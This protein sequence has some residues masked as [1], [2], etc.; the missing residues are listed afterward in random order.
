MTDLHTLRALRL[1]NDY[2]AVSFAIYVFHSAM[3]ETPD[4][5]VILGVGKNK[6]GQEVH[7][8]EQKER[9]RVLRKAPHP[10][11]ESPLLYMGDEGSRC[12]ERG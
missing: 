6:A 4:V 12:P 7:G 8:R 2:D 3:V 9:S 1:E 5:N 11:L 10:H